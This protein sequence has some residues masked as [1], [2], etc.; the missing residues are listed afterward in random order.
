MNS[1]SKML[2]LFSKF[3]DP[4]SR[5]I[6]FIEWLKDDPLLDHRF[7]METMMDIAI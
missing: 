2:F 7:R 1:F 6:L 3:D 4:E 5:W